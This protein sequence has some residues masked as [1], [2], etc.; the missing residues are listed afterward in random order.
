MR[1]Q[2]T[3]DGGRRLAAS[4]AQRGSGVA[5]AATPWMNLP[6]E[7]QGS[8]PEKVDVA[9]DAGAAVLVWWSGTTTA[10]GGVWGW[11][12]MVEAINH[13]RMP[14]RGFHG[15]RLRVA[16][17]RLTVLVQALESSRYLARCSLVGE[18]RSW[19]WRPWV[20]GGGR[21]W[22]GSNCDWAQGRAGGGTQAEP[23]GR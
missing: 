20:P 18:G 5:A 2:R 7:G 3:G 9:G 23:P 12:A 10:S 15:D 21:G 13:G 17:A 19:R 1:W 4:Q 22:R 14:A 16:G 11:T 6:R 8:P